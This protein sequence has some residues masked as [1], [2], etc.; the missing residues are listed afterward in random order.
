[1]TADSVAVIA[2]HAV[3]EGPGPIC[4][5]PRVFE[6]HVHALRDAGCV[7]LTMTQVG[8]HLRTGTPFPDRAVALTFDDGYASVVTAA[9][10][11]LDRL[12]WRAT[13]FPV[14]SELGGHNRW[15]TSGG[16]HPELRLVDRHQILDLLDAGW[17][18][19]GHTH[20][21][22]P[23]PGLPPAAAADEIDTSTAVLEDLCQRPVRT[24]A[25]PY[26]S[27]DAT[28]RDL[29]GRRHETCLTI[30]ARRA[31]LGTSLDRV[32]RIEAWYLQRAWHAEHLHDRVGDAYLGLRR[33]TR[34]GRAA[35]VRRRARR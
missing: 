16:V 35:L 25:Y 8:D 29:A 11:V 34:R 15:D 33:L 10:P 17:E 3:E 21:H 19:G 30:G 5:A 7:P 18:V 1:M 28:A 9:A 13:V 2:Y 6:R 14:T 23:L 4:L 24:F 26:G 31:T 12:G 32:D 20:T 27:H 22:R